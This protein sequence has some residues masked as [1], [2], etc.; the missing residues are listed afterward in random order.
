MHANEL[1]E[2]LRQAIRWGE[3]PS[4]SVLVQEQL[5]KPFNVQP[6]S[7]PRG[8]SHPGRGWTGGLPFR[9]GYAVKRL[10]ALEAEEI[11][12][13]RLLIEPLLA[14]YTIDNAGSA[15]INRWSRPW[16]ARTS[17]EKHGWS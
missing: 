12:D 6:V 14:G 15:L 3:L 2:E 11:H 13:L 10:D 9:G 8:A 4:G 7:G 5:A 16:R 1:A 17:A